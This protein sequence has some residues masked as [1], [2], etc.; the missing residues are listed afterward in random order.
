MHYE[1]QNVRTPFEKETGLCGG[2]PKSF[3]QRLRVKNYKRI[4]ILSFTEPIKLILQLLQGDKNYLKNLQ[5]F[6][7]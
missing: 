5:D 2:G 1:H 6:F 7:L 3:M 4:R